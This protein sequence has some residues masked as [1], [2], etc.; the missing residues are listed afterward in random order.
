MEKELDS[1]SVTE[2]LEMPMFKRS[3]VIAGSQNLNNKCKNITI[4][5][6]PEG[7]E[8]LEGGE[9][10]LSTGYAFKD[11]E[12]ALKNV[13][14]RAFKRKAAAIAIKEKRYIESIPKEMI[15]QANKYGI[16][17]IK[18][19]HDLVYTS[20]ITNFYNSL[21][22]KK[23]R[24][25]YEAK[26]MHEKLLTIMLEN[27][28]VEGTVKALSNLTNFSIIIV[29][30]VFN[31][32]AKNV[33]NGHNDFS[34][35]IKED[36]MVLSKISNIS[37]ISCSVEYKNYIIN[38]YKIIF[39]SEIIGYMYVISDSHIVGLNLEAVTKVRNILA[40]K[41]EK[42]REEPLN[43]VNINKIIT[44]IILNSKKLPEEFYMNIKNNYRWNG[45]EEFVGLCVEFKSHGLSNEKRTKLSERVCSLISRIF[46]EKGFFLTEDINKLTLFFSIDEELSLDNIISKIT[47]FVN[48]Y[49]SNVKTAFSISR[50]YKDIK[51]IPK[52]YKECYIASLFNKNEIIYYDT[53]DT[54][55][56]LYSLGGNAQTV[57]YC[58]KTVGNI[59]KYDNENKSE[60][61]KTLTAFF[62]YDMNK[63]LISQK[64][65]IHPETLR[66]RLKKIYELT[67]Y[68]VNT[69]EG[70]FALE[71]GIKL[72]RIMNINS[73]DIK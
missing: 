73:T 62:K 50:T 64:L 11:D 38:E 58:K 32:I 21:L 28:N 22:Y 53:L 46:N 15:I 40:F 6:T 37:D 52:M 26:E 45:R 51:D 30:N 17:L 18:L 23:N 41:L 42:E 57:E 16:P 65:H 69:T 48:K 68:S 61:M 1:L 66:Y 54:I 60:L 67:G 7:L 35:D 24:Y 34:K 29:D 36:N 33:I 59:E 39:K 25:I 10:I 9:F 56:I 5:E 4:L 71:M 19:P 20:T 70:I 14:Y 47:V 49:D 12:G 63:K 8:W 27:K 13:V 44:N 31:I 72:Q 43:I 3:I 2:I 55:K